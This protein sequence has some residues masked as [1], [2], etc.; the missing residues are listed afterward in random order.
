[1]KTAFI[2]MCVGWLISVVIWLYTLI[3]E[4]TRENN[5]YIYPLIAMCC[6]NLAIQLINIF[7]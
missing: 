2:L 7:I 3:N 1:M 6:F 5:S 4:K